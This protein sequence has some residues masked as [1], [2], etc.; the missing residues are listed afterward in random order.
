M[1]ERMLREGRVMGARA[2]YLHTTEAGR[3]LYECLGFRT[4]GQWTTF[5]A[6]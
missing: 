5:S 4:V 6:P 3:R 2:A 1:T